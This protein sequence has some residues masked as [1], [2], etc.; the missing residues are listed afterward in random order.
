MT[1]KVF[2]RG[3]PMKIG[4]ISKRFGI[5]VCTVRM[6]A[7]R[8][9]NRKMHEGQS[10]AIFSEKE[11]Y[12]PSCPRGYARNEDDDKPQFTKAW[13]NMVRARRG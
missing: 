11:L 3:R 2:V 5:Q 10:C 6:R 8:C 13:D 12:V 4:E 7:R 1:T 9:K